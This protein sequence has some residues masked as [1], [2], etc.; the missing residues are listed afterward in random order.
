VQGALWNWRYVDFTRGAHE[1]Y[2]STFTVRIGGLPDAVLTIDRDAIRR[3]FTGDPLLKRHGNDMLRPALGDQSV[4]QLDPPEHLERRKLLLPPFHGERIRAYGRLVD[5]LIDRELASWRPG[6]TVAILPRAQ[7]LTLEVILR[8]VFGIP[9]AGLRDRLRRL[10]DGLTQPPGSSLGFIFPRLTGNWNPLARHLWG[11]K[12]ELDAVVAAQ[13]AASRQDPALA[14]RDDILAMLIQARDENGEGLS[15]T[16]LLHE[17]NTLLAA[18][19]ETTA[20]AIAWGVQLLAHHPDVLARTRAALEAGEDEYL[21]ALVKEVLRIRPP[22]PIGG[23]RHVLEPFPMGE[24]TIGPEVTIIINGWGIHHDPAIYPEP[25]KL[26]PERFL[27]AKPDSYAFLAFGGGAHRCLGAA[28]AQLEIKLVLGAIVSRFELEPVAP[29]IAPP[30]RRATALVPRG[31]GR[32]RVAGARAG[33]QLS[34][35]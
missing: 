3:L 15:D 20:T 6:E 12:H 7:D 34:T 35:A 18:G 19:H 17:L 24:H 29:E 14:E 23:A 1:R 4:M 25:E 8:A 32:V 33:R 31:G 27:E 10:Y 16:A 28:L 2:G 13:I 22:I 5:E 9:D 21:D 30:T 26:R 11:K